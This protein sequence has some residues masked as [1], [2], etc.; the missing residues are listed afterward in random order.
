LMQI[1]DAAAITAVKTLQAMMQ[2]SEIL[3]LS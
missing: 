3:H 2:A 1:L